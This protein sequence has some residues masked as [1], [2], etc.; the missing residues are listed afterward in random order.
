MSEASFDVVAAGHICL[1]ISPRFPPGRDVAHVGEIFHPGTL[2]QMDGATVSTGGSVS[3][4]GINLLTLGMK[5]ELMGKI[6]DDFFAKGILDLL[7]ARRLDKSMV[8]VPGEQT[9][10]TVVL[11]PPGIDR[12]FLHCPGANDTFGADDVN[13]DVV[14]RARLF[15][16]G[17][18][19]IMKRIQANGGRELAAMFR[20]VRE[21]GTV[22]TSLD[23]AMPD[24]ASEA[25]RADW[26]RILETA[27]PHVDIFL[28]SAEELLFML[29]R[30]LFLDWRERA[31]RDHMDLLDLLTGDV[32]TRLG[33]R[34]LDMG[35]KVI[36]IKCGSRG[37]YGRTAS[38]KTMGKVPLFR[39][40]NRAREWG[41]REIWRATFS[42]DRVVSATGAGDSAIAGFLASALRGLT[43][44][45]SVEM[46]CAVG[47]CNVSAMDALSGVLSWDET[48]RR[49]AAGWKPNPTQIRG[50]G[51]TPL[52]P[53]TLWA[54]PRHARA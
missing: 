38:A 16:F 1:D 20:R 47:A 49:I 23:L 8:R 11:A 35:A 13:Y 18:P 50:T 42:V 34:L 3:N 12:I 10:Y 36:L 39:D 46:A 21:L 14:S 28:P 2:L 41:A 19:P 51:W 54:G 43:F 4:T 45:D 25:G 40:G 53:Q 15:H 44:E 27:L 32:L 33:D 30:E 7:A 5:V 48:R 52:I 29:E 37:V 24:P 22:A 9:S 6:G 31:T 26:I 17:Y